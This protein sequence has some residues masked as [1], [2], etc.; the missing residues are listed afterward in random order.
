MIFTLI[1]ILFAGLLLKSFHTRYISE[2]RKYFSF[3]DRRFTDDDYLKVQDLNIGRLEGIFLFIMLGVLLLAL[4]VHLFIDPVLSVWLIGLFLAAMLLLSLIVDLKLHTV[5][6]DRSHLVMA[7]I[8]FGVIAG[9]FIFLFARGTEDVDV[10]FEDTHASMLPD[11]IGY[12]YEEIE[13]IEMVD[14]MPEIPFNH[15]VL[16]TLNQRH[17]SFSKGDTFFR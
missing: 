13:R 16:G 8:W 11:H 10:V 9:I 15:N 6:Y 17:G 5:T 14:A 12:A 4:G 7:V 3:D 2:K 1:Y